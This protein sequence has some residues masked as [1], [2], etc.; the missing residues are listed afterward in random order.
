MKFLGFPRGC[1]KFLGLNKP[2]A[3]RSITIGIRKEEK[4]SWESR[5]PLTPTHIHELISRFGINFI[6]QPSN[7]RVFSDNEYS[8]VTFMKLE[9]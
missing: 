1:K 9:W 5:A 4:N 8:M 3:S 6:V 7:T 2:Y